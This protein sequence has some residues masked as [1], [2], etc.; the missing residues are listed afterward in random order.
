MSSLPVMLSIDPGLRGCG[1]AWWEKGEAGWRLASAAYVEAV[2]HEPEDRDD[3][4]PL[5]WSA[6]VGAVEL[7]HDARY[8]DTMP[9]VLVVERMKVYARGVGDPRDLLALAAI[10]GGLVR[11]FYGARA[12]GL[13]PATWK[14]QVP[15]KVM[16]ERVEKHLRERGEWERVQRPRR[17]ANVNDVMHAAGLG[18][19]CIDRGRV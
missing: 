6:M 17:A 19:F 8:P 12:I 3:D 10:G 4:G 9:E 13:L 7:A 16:G 5:A 2:P 1:C 14:G 18:L 15:R 11:A